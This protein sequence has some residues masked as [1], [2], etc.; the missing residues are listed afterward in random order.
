MEQKVNRM[1]SFL[2]GTMFSDTSLQAPEMPPPASR[3]ERL[4]TIADRLLD[5]IEA[6]VDA[7]HASELYDLSETLW[8]VC[9][10]KELVMGDD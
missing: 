5:R 3:T 4:L 2:D 6:E 8:N 10:A 1:D 7:G 9:S